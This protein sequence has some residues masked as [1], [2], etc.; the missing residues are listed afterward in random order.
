[1]AATTK[2]H[3]AF[4]VTP[5]LRKRFTSYVVKAPNGCHIWT[6]AIQ[7][8]GYGAFRVG[9][10][11]IDAHV[12]AWRTANSG[13]PVPV[14]QLV[15]HKC[16]NRQC[17]NPDHLHLGTHSDNMKDAVKNGGNEIRPRG[18][19]HPNAVLSEPL[20]RAIRWMSES[21]N[22]GPAEIGRMIGV[23]RST[24]AKVIRGNSWVHVMSTEEVSA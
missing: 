14:G 17:V 13:K 18:E 6:G 9:P 10:Q 20:V 22:I 19:E 21:H 2:L 3:P 23:D 24:V 7:R 5:Q 1:M 8:H 15:R 12:V 4:T 11:K 16:N